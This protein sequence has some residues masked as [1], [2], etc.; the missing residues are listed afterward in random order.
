MKTTRPQT[1]PLIQEQPPQLTMIEMEFNRLLLTFVVCQIKFCWWETLQSSL[2]LRIQPNYRWLFFAN[3]VTELCFYNFE[4]IFLQNSMFCGSEVT[5]ESVRMW[6]QL[7]HLKLLNDNQNHDKQ[8][9]S[10]VKSEYFSIFCHWHQWHPGVNYWKLCGINL[11]HHL[12][13]KTKSSRK[14]F[15]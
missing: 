13:K 5:V 11:T 3:V 1:K 10:R 15:L 8:Q 6:G 2:K 9:Q 12:M 14:H 4:N 7:K